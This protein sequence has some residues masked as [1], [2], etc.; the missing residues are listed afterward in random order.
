MLGRYDVIDIMSIK[1]N[2]IYERNV[3]SLQSKKDIEQ[4]SIKNVFIN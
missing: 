2:L 4:G 1:E 3:I